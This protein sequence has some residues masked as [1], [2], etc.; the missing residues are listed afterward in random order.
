MT[1]NEQTL[2]WVEEKNGV[3]ID[4]TLDIAVHAADSKVILLTIPGVDGSVNGFN[5]KYVQIAES[6]WEQHGAAVVR[7][8]NPF[9]T[10]FHWE[11]NIRHI[12]EYIEQNAE[13]ICGTADYELRVM[14]HSAGASVMA[15]LAGEYPKITKLLL[16]NP[17]AKL[18]LNRMK[19]GLY[20]SACNQITVIFGEQDP[21]VEFVEELSKADQ[22][23]RMHTFVLEGVDHHFSGKA[24]NYF[25]QAPHS[26]LFGQAVYL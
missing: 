3:S 14:A 18:G 9:I 26:H 8:E 10:S 4:C 2:S 12:M 7:M 16:M 13:D 17:A 25:L 21:S 23:K 22:S 19:Q 11:S 5:N 20:L 6:V 24:F 1:C 15:M